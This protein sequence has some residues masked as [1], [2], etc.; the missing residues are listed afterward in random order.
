MNNEDWFD[1]LYIIEVKYDRKREATQI[2]KI[3]TL[4]SASH[5]NSN[6]SIRVPRKKK[7]R[8][9]VF[10]KQQGKTPKHHGVPRY[11]ILHKKSVIT[12]RKYMLHRYDDCFFNCY[13][14]KYSKEG[15]SISIGNRTNAVKQYKKSENKR[16]KELKVLKNQNKMVYSIVKNFG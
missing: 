11:C 2:K 16:K 15:M 3:A 7:A 13:D 12:E 14:H 8:T 10:H 4:R 5:F 9:G 1:L 6:K